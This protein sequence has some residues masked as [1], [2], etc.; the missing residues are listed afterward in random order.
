MTAQGW[1]GCEPEDCTM[2][3]DTSGASWRSDGDHP[4]YEDP[5]WGTDPAEDPEEEE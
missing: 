3:G 2:P 4:K 5:F 1:P